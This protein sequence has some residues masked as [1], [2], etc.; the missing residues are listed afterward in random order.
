[1]F[2]D[3]GT[4]NDVIDKE[5][6]L[7]QNIGVDHFTSVQALAAALPLAK[8]IDPDKLNPE[9]IL[10]DISDLQNKSC[11]L[12]AQIESDEKWEK[13]KSALELG[14]AGVAFAVAD[15]VGAYLSGGSL[16][17][18]TQFSFT[19]GGGMIVKAAADLNSPQ[20]P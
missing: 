11:S 1:M 12:D 4:V 14:V 19:I 3:L 15:G 7:L 10:K 5:G 2:S 17:Y 8:T 20:A 18:V 9:L 13:K 6:H 16:A